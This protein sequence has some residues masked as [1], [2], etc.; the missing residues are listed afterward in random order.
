M[1]NDIYVTADL[2]LRGE[3][4]EPSLL[5]FR[6]L[7]Q[8]AAEAHATLYIVGDL[9]DYW[10]GPRQAKMTGFRNILDIL[11][12]TAAR[13]PIHVIPGNRDFAMGAEITA[14]GGVVLHPHDVEVAWSGGRALLTHGDL[15]LENDRAYQRMRMVLRA[16]PARAL[17]RVLPLA[18]SLR[19]AGALRR[20]SHDAVS[21]KP[22]SAFAI[23]FRRVRDL[24][25]R[26]GYD[27][28]VAG[29]VHRPGAYAG[30]IGGRA[31]RFLTLGAWGARGWVV[32]LPAHGEAVLER[33]PGQDGR[34]ADQPL[35]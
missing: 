13:V 33:F 14:A 3:P 30:R 29:H 7:C 11:A 26:G 22:A 20:K 27:L 25:Q 34:P 23:S 31:R 24:F 12:A 1:K 5:G 19:L 28:I 2:H 35:P 6:A 32:R 17:L 16:P 8:H 10:V 15:L 4:N 21:R 9:F 18:A